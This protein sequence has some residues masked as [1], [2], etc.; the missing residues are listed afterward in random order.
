[1]TSSD[2]ASRELHRFSI[3]S[4]SDK[5]WRSYGKLQLQSIMFLMVYKKYYITEFI[6]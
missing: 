2:R 1:M 5:Y 3:S 4:K 6:W